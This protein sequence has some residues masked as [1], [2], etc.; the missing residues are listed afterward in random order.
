MTANVV[1]TRFAPSPTGLIH[2]G[3]VRTAL[4]N[5]LLAR[6]RGGIFLL[7]IEDT[8]QERSRTEYVTQ[9]QEDLR[10][11][12]LDWDEGPEA[13]GAA[14]P[15]FQSQ[16]SDIY[17]Q[18]YQ[19]LE[20]LGL[21]Y[22]C[23]C[24]PRE[25]EISRKLQ[26]A[27]GKAP[28][29]AGT[30]AHLK[31][32]EVARKRA[33]GLQPSLRFRVARRERIEFTD[34]VRGKQTYLGEDIGDF[35]IRRGDGTPAFFF[36]NAIDDALMGV[37]HVL[38]GEDHLTNTPRQ[39]LMLRALG[40]TEP[41][42]AHISMIVGSDGAPLSKRSGSQSVQELREQ[43]KLPLGVVNYLARLGHTYELDDFQS[44][45]ALAE[46]FSLERLGKAPARFDP[47]QMRHWEKSA[48]SALDAGAVW[49]W[50]GAEVHNLVPESQK[51]AFIETVH[52]NLAA[53]EDGLHWA[54]VLFNADWTP[55]EAAQAEIQA[56]GADFFQAALEQLESAGCDWKALANGVKTTTGKKGKGL[57]MPLRAALTGEVHGPEMG[58][59]LPLLGQK[60]ARNRLQRATEV[61]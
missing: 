32:E 11:L 20:D 19:R 34:L 39:L 40:L 37:T 28:K 30:C 26:R 47:Q 42:Y 31:P 17:P 25:L 43:G 24:S 45:D 41:Q 54:K 13:D 52:P 46:H 4:F 61:D 7:R 21:A 14:G 22:P 23:F 15:Y 38:R 5:A 9:L 53:P 1:K 58:K 55:S 10:W 18:Y 51:N 3:N 16:R 36:C 59:V 2:T 33:E 6:A 49:D 12:G 44:L 48:V 56:A 29:Y 27:S 8:D 50:L 35:I 57:F 60:E